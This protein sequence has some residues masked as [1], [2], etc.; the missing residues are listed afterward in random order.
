MTFR[1]VILAR[2]ICVVLIDFFFSQA[3]PPGFQE[4]DRGGSNLY[5]CTI[6]GIQVLFY[7]LFRARAYFSQ[8][9]L[10]QTVTASGQSS[11]PEAGRQLS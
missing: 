4:S 6:L 2:L 8:S 3:A 9:Q 10:V 5:L 11:P 7:F 1:L